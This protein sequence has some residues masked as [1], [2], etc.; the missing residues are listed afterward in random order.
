MLIIRLY[1]RKDLEKVWDFVL[2]NFEEYK[3]KT[4]KPLYISQLAGKNCISVILEVEHVN[5]IME[6]LSEEIAGCEE[7]SK[8]KT[9]SL[10]KP[11]FL[12]IPKKRPKNLNRYTVT[13]KLDPK[14]YKDIYK[15][16]IDY[17]YPSKVFPTYITYVLGRWD[18]MLS[19]NGRNH[20]EVF[21][22]VQDRISP[23]KGVREF[24]IIHIKRCRPIA[25][26][27]VWREFQ[28][29]LLYLPSWMTSEELKEKYLYDYR[30]Y[31]TDE[32]GLTGAM[33]DEL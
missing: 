7:I 11:V 25:S 1:P 5:H 4:V 18:L 20:E 6:F 9:I 28:K 32:Y 21:G 29:S 10:V 16:L 30:I 15:K 3:S 24:S 8:T 17:R 13:L 12:P 31:P 22:F 14:R 33:V 27:E 2:K 23:M 19:L 26:K